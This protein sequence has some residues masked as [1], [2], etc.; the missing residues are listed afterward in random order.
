MLFFRK[1]EFENGNVGDTPNRSQLL[2]YLYNNR[3]GNDLACP[4]RSQFGVSPS[5]LSVPIK[6][7]NKSYNQYQ[8]KHNLS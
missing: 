6:F 2:D 5:F 7:K 4:Q 1:G 3:K 8:E